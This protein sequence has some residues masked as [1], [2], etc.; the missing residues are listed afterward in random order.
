MQLFELEG[1]AVVDVVA[2]VLFVGEHLAHSAVRPGPLVVGADALVVESLRNF[3]QGHVVLDEPSKHPQD[4]GH[5]VI[6]AGHED[7]AVGLQAFVLA[8]FELAF[9][10]AGL[11]NQHPAQAVACWTPLTKPHLNQAALTGEHLGRQLPAVFPGHGALDAFDDGRHRRAVVLKLLG[12][13]GDRDTFAL[14]D[15]FVISRLVRILEATPAA[16]VIDQDQ[17]EVG[18]AGLD[19]GDELLQ[20]GAAI[21]GQP[22]LALV[23][24]GAHDL[25]AAPVSVFLNLVGLVMRGVLLMLGGHAHVLGG[26]ECFGW[27][28]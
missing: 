21:D 23:G 6:G 3:S 20:R 26:T 12:H 4:S 11:V 25:N 16:D 18:V 17:V 13:V 1:M 14:A 7:D 24:I 8:V 2:D 9:D 22:A 27:I 28:F 19:I 5:F 15:V 10:G